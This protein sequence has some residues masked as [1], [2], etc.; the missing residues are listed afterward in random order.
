VTP[1]RPATSPAVFAPVLRW[2]RG[3]ASPVHRDG[4]ALIL[5]AGV[6]SVLGLLFWV[7]AARLY[8]PAAVGLN[9]V[10][11]SAM[12]LLGQL[13]LL[14]L[15]YVL[16]RFLPV[17]GGGTR[18][19]VLGAYCVSGALSGIAATVFVLGAGLWAPALL[20]HTGRTQLML[21]IVPA[22]VV[23]TIF[24]LQD[25]VLT[26]VKRATVVPVEN[27]VFAV[28]KIALLVAA[29]ATLQED[30]VAASWVVATAVVVVATNAY[31]FL[32]ALPAHEIVTRDV[33]VPLSLAGARQFVVA[34]YAGATFWSAATFGLPMLVIAVVGPVGAGVYGIAW[35]IAFS[36]YLVSSS[37][38]QSLV[39]HLA[40]DPDEAPTAR[41][42][43]EV[44]ALTLL[45]PAVAVLALAA[46]VVLGLFGEDYAQLGTGVLVLAALSSLPN[47]I[48]TS[49]VSV[50]RVQRRLPVLVAVP[51]GISTLT[52][53]L[54]LLLLPRWGVTGVGMAWLVSQTLVAVTI[55]VLRAA[56][57]PGPLGALVGASRRKSLLRQVIRD[58]R[59]GVFRD[60]R[61]SW[62]VWE[63]L[64]GGSDTV[65]VAIGPESGPR[66]V[67][68]VGSTA[69]SRASL[70][71]EHETLKALQA[72][73]RLGEWRDLLPKVLDTAD[74]GS[75]RYALESRL[76]G[77]SGLEALG[78]PRRADAYVTNAIAAISELHRRTAGAA[79]VDE[80]HL[81][82]W[83][84][85][86]AACLR[87]AVGRRQQAAVLRIEHELGRRLYGRTVP[88]GWTHGDFCAVNALAHDDGAVAGIVDWGQA[89][90]RGF[91]VV[92]VVVFQL[93]A[94]M[95]RTDRE[96]GLIVIDRLARGRAGDEDLTSLQ[97]DLGTDPIDAATLV[98]LGW[99]QHIGS[100]LAKAPKFAANPVW[101]RRNVVSVLQGLPVSPSDPLVSRTN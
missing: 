101:M 92:D 91:P 51:A 50:A 85:A 54:S 63:R 47:I 48:T 88:V 65:V 28:L 8:T 55:M 13:A 10:A 25:F 45:V 38:G 11:L 64:A 74:V 58:G 75:A 43:M 39:A 15:N 89:D 4:L 23:W 35:T 100:N 22:T 3:W 68:K 93:L 46:P 37:M 79:P 73:A 26:A 66:A 81:A 18:R 17:A 59:D 82:H 78:D 32:R 34:D 69:P 56:W 61:A 87:R 1:L 21:F 42:S 90:P 5:S 84:G 52:I 77:R 41:R 94:E 62:H 57:L 2:L 97:R 86:P 70:Q 76:P 44:R 40:T 67:L 98:L 72:D 7:L 96:V 14:N 95:T 27:A 20:A 36:L 24:L 99:L 60:D 80:E 83:V 16:L 9:S 6:T 12:M 31:L 29:V 53:A 49:T 71:R 19:L 33:A 30:G